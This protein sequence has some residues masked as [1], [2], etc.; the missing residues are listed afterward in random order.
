MAGLSAS[1]SVEDKSARNGP[2]PRLIPV[3]PK[4]EPTL[5][6]PESEEFYAEAV[7]QLVAS[8]VPFLLAGTYAV[9]AYTGISRQTKDMDVFCRPAHYPQILAHFKKLGYRIAIE[10]ER[11]IAK[12]FKG[13]V[14]LDVIFASAAGTIPVDDLW[15]EHAPSTMVFGTPVRVVGPTE[16]IWSKSFVQ[17]RDRHDGADIAHVILRADVAIDWQRLLACMGPHWELLLAHLLH[18]RW[19]YPSE[20]A[21]I[22]DWL[23]DEL[24]GRVAAQRHQPSPP[25]RVCRGR[26]VSSADYKIDIARWGFADVDGNGEAKT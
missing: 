23:M 7:R 12:V 9:S 18:F 11:W 15:F 2:L 26:L 24:L 17:A 20:H 13:R 22:P 19:L 3:H 8:G 6:N 10:D 25:S 5:Q 21:R 14:F 1:N 4:A 16:L